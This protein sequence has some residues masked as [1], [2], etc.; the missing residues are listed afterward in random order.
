MRPQSWSVPTAP[1]DWA[2]YAYWERRS[3]LRRRSQRLG[4]QA[5]RNP[6]AKWKFERY[7]RRRRAR[8]LALG[9]RS[10]ISRGGPALKCGFYSPLGCDA[11]EFQ[12]TL[13]L[14]H[15]LLLHRLPC[16]ASRRRALSSPLACIAIATHAWIRVG[17]MDCFPTRRAGTDL[18]QPMIQP[19]AANDCVYRVYVPF[20]MCELQLRA[21]ACT[22]C[23][24][25]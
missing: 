12:L 22:A 23:I 17:R 2:L 8:I 18:P 14:T 19:A 7:R 21:T 4:I 3:S 15:N 10:L 6:L 20:Q 16:P 9:I 1:M 5:R 25:Q 24:P 13:T 11:I